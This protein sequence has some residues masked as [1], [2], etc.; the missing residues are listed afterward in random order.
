MQLK[1]LY[2]R[3]YHISLLTPRSAGLRT[4]LRNDTVETHNPSTSK[5]PTHKENAYTH[6]NNKFTYGHKT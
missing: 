2:I 4:R 6:K 5:L 3:T 1:I